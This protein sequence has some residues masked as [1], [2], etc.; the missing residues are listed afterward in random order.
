MHSE[1]FRISTVLRRIRRLSGWVSRLRSRRLEPLSRDWGFDRGLPIDRHYIEDFL[2]RTAHL[3][4]GRVLEVKD[5][6]YT[7]RFG[8]QSVLRC[9]VLD[10]DPTNKNATIIDDLTYGRELPADAYDCIVLTQVLQ[11]IYDVP[12]AM[13]TLYRVLRPGGSLL[14][15]VPGITQIAYDRLGHTWYWAFY[16]ASVTKLLQT[17][18]PADLVEVHVYGNV[19][20]ATSMLYGRAAEE[21][22]LAEL[23]PVDLDYPVIV[24]ARATKPTV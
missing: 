5:D 22:T 23:T 13:Q 14:L 21:L 7:R 24:A 15:T 11:L 8:G 2:H 17:V 19:L 1:R 6:A 3:I 9:D 18:F 12:S 20:S 4:R 10:I 16:E